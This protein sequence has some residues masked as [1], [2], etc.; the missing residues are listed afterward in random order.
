MVIDPIDGSL[1][2]KRGLPHFALSIAVADGPTMADVV[3]GFVQDFG[4]EE[5]WVARRG[6]GAQLDGMPL[7][8]T[9]VERRNRDGKLEVLGSSRPIR[10]GSC[11]PPTRSSETAHRLRAIGAIAVSL[12]QVAAGALRRDGVA[13]ALPRRR[14]RGGAAD[15]ARGGRAGGLHRLRRPAGARRWTS[16][17]ARR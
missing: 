8:P 10:A 6:E 16:S 13:E 1:N 14:C 17:R 4:P 9:L 3:F 11:S 12:C 2:A 7:D 15:R 5:E